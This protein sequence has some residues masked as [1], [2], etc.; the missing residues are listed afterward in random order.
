MT[1]IIQNRAMFTFTLFLFLVVTFGCN[2]KK[3]QPAD[4]LST[5][6]SGTKYAKGFQ[7]TA[8]EN[9]KRVVIYNPWDADKAKPFAV[10]YLCENDSIS[11][12]D[13]GMRLKIPL[14]S[15]VV[16]TF[17]Y[18]EFLRQLDELDK[19][20]GVTDAPR[21]YNSAILQ[22]IQEKEIQN[23][24]DP[25]T[26]NVE[27]TLMLRPDAII[28]S[29]Y[30]QQDTYNER[31]LNAGLPIIYSLEW[32]ENSPLARAE[33]I[34]LIAAFFG[35]ESV[36]DSIFNDIESR[37]IAK[38]DI[39]ENLQQKTTVLAGDNFQNT[40][41]VP[42]GKSFNANLFSDAGLD[43]FYKD[44]A[45][46]GSIGLDIESVLTQFGSADFWFGCEA[47]TYD[48]LARKDKKY[49]LLKSVKNRQV[50]NNRRRTTPSGGNDYFESAIAHPDL[51]LS[52]LIK[53]V[54]P[55]LLPEAEFTYNKPLE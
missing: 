43:Y 32:M 19:V 49:L 4:N 34:K 24:G 8:F 16:N 21:I 10:Y 30:A 26:P 15:M 42:G 14:N 18:F 29:A 11:V 5:G 20:I 53:A 7:I 52:D 31:L 48:E 38:K 23:L 51:I 6:S 55:E 33:W 44:N 3:H 37:Y 1:S 54:H 13:D 50:F 22:K 45:E 27:K 46:S 28:K 9:Y 41:Y 35:K 39:V 2:Q 47:D 12:P 36:A 25:F 40:W 17:S